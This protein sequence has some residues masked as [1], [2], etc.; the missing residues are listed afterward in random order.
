MNRPRIADVTAAQAK[1]AA[2]SA[3]RR[4]SA[5]RSRAVGDAWEAMLETQH[6]RYR[7]LGLADVRKIPTPMKPITGL[8]PGNG[9]RPV[10]TAVYQ[11]REHIDFEGLLRGGRAVRVEGKATTD[12]G[13]VSLS[14]VK[15]HQAAALDLCDQLGGFAAVALLHPAGMFLIPWANWRPTT[16][17]QR[18]L[19]SLAPTDLEVRGARFADHRRA[20]LVINGGSAPADWIGA[21]QQKGWIR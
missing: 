7:S 2:A 3:K 4:R 9:G 13:R 17:G 10:C 11:P 8:R 12:P 20:Q 15:D 5:K 16:H 14:L 1:A 18:Q 19:V 21:A 6:A